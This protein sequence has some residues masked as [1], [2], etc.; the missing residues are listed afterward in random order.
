M[1]QSLSPLP[2]LTRVVV[3][4]VDQTPSATEKAKLT[5]YTN[6]D[7][8]LS[9]GATMTYKWEKRDLG[10]NPDD[11]NAWTTLEGKTARVIELGEG[12][13]GYVRCTV[14]YA[15]PTSVFAQPL[16][17]TSV[18][19]TNEARVRVMPAAPSGLTVSNM[20]QT[21]AAISWTQGASGVAFDLTYRAVGSSEWI[22]ARIDS[23]NALQ[24]TDLKPGTVY[25]W[26]MRSVAYGDSAEQLC[27]DWVTG[28][29]FTTL[30]E[31]I[32]FSRVEVTPSAKSVMVD[33]NRTIELTAKT[34]ADSDH[35]QLTYQWQRL[36]GSDWVPVDGA[37]DD[38]LQVSAKGLS[39]G[40]HTYRCEV[41]ATRG[42]KTKTLD[43]NESVVTVMPAAPTD[44]SVSDIHRL[45]P[46]DPNHTNVEATFHWAWDGAVGQ[47][48]EVQFEAELS[49]DCRRRCFGGVE[50]GNVRLRREHGVRDVLVG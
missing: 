8:M 19:S 18:I 25:E 12:A 41:T 44:L 39:V 22:S 6:V 5:A 7:D 35:E 36:D 40:A 20:N 43:S 34:D 29:P 17:N 32:V 11:P 38:A 27:S 14:T 30:P 31:E 33:T 15:P 21:T 46:D 16:S 24:L 37:T 49:K 45:Y 3:G 42:V 50:I 1:T 23:G 47:Q 4:P 10:S 48:D 2:Q 9:T 28:P 13:V 26:A